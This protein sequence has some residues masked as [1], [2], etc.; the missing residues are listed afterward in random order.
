VP[1]EHAAVSVDQAVAHPPDFVADAVLVST[2][3]VPPVI[4]TRGAA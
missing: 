3:K 4:W 2:R 1:V